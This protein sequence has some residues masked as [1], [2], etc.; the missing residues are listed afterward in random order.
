MAG[1]CYCNPGY[2]GE[3]CKSQTNF[4]CL[5]DGYCSGHGKCYNGKCECNMDYVGEICNKR[6]CRLE[7]KYKNFERECSGHGTCKDNGCFCDPGYGGPD[8]ETVQNE[9]GCPMN[10]NNRGRCENGVCVC[11]S[12]YSFED[13]C[14]APRS[15]SFV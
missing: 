14:L 2:Y 5:N 4:M 7:K 12:G 3:D 11:I 9:V 1:K 8:C 6:E 10:C 15:T 13:N